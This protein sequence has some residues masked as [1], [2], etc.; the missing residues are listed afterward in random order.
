LTKYSSWLPAFVLSEI[1][2]MILI[3][4][5]GRA[6]SIYDRTKMKLKNDRFQLKQATLM[7]LL[8]SKK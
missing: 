2:L 5:I 6:Y 4:V 8:T 7:Q 1:S 3:I